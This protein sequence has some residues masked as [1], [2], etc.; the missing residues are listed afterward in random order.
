[1][2]Y[3]DDGVL[4]ILGGFKLSVVYV[5]P[6]CAPSLLSNLGNFLNRERFIS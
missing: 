4:Q 1:M 3:G 2:N 6:I 5:D